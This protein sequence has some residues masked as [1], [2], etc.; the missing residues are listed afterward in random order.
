[1]KNMIELFNKLGEIDY[2]RRQMKKTESNSD[3]GPSAQSYTSKKSTKS[4]SSGSS[5]KY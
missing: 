5:D 4:S 1:M 3:F 2:V